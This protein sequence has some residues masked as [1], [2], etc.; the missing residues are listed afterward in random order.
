M[1][2]TTVLTTGS[3]DDAGQGIEVRILG[4]THGPDHA[5]HGDTPGI[6]QL[7]RFPHY[8]HAWPGG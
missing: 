8:F 2:V 6:H 1:V 4:C 7:D 3:A 5:H